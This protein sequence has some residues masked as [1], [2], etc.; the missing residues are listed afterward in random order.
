M[1]CSSDVVLP[2]SSTT[3]MVRMS[4]QSGPGIPAF[5]DIGGRGCGPTAIVFHDGPKFLQ[6]KAGIVHADELQ[7]ANPP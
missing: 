4:T 7:S 3:S 5:E 1:V 6:I 2:Q